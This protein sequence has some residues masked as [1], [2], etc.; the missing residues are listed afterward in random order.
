MENLISTRNYLI[1]QV[2]T[3]FKMVVSNQ[4]RVDF[5]LGR[6]QTGLQRGIIDEPQAE[7]LTQQAQERQMLRYPLDMAMTGLS[8]FSP[9]LLPL[10]WE[11]SGL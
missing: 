11:I 8:E 5:M 6:I 4:R 1:D 7:R 10:I 3:P 2:T 9:L